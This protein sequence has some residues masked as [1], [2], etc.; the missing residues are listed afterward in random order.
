M[1]NKIRE[2]IVFRP[3]AHDNLIQALPRFQ[4]NVPEV[5]RI[6]GFRYPAPGSAGLKN[7]EHVS[8]PIREN[9]DQVYDTK[10]YSRDSRNLKYNES[11]LIN[12]KEQVMFTPDGKYGDRTYGQEGKFKNPAVTKYDPSGLRATMNT[13]WAAMDASLAVNAKPNHLVRESWRNDKE[14]PEAEAERKGLPQPVG[15]WYGSNLNRSKNYTE[16][17]W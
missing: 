4:Q 13:T 8:I 9:S 10:L 1:Y 12:T 5:P 14:S 6:I 3:E 15:R 11:M 2:M 16:V 7:E 17:R